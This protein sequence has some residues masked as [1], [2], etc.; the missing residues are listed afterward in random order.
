MPGYDIPYLPFVSLI[1]LLAL[2]AA[3]ESPREAARIGFAAGT[4]ANLLIYYWIAWTVA[5]PGNLGW[6][7]GAAAAL[8]VSAFVAGF[9]SG[10][11]AV[12]NYCLRR[13]GGFALWAFPFFWT[14]FELGRTHLFTGFPWMLLGYSLAGSPL[15]RQA[16]DLAG[17]LG[18][19]FLIAMVNVAAYR[20]ITAI[21]ERNIRA[22]AVSCLVVIGIPVSMVLY[23]NL[24]LQSPKG[25]R[26]LP[27]RIGISQG[28]IDQNRKWDPAN[29]EETISIYRKLTA[30]AVAQGAR[31][32][33][34]P[35][36]AAPFFYG[37]ESALTEL[38]DNVARTNATPIVF[39][40]PW[41]NPEGGGKYFN[42]VFYLNA[43][44]IPVGR[45]DK[46]HLVPFGEYVPLRHLLPFISKLTAGEEDFSCGTGPLLF[47]IDNTS[48]AASICYEAVFPEIIRESVLAG[49]GWLINVTNDAWFGDTVAPYQHL[50]MARMRAVELRRPMV[51]AANSGISAVID[52][53]GEVVR[54]LGLFKKGIVVADITPETGQTAY[55]KTGEL[56]GFSCIII[57]FLTFLFALR[58]PHGNRYPGG[59]NKRP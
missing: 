1:P 39:G 34:W 4:L 41:F 56:F 48:A 47:G 35:E 59:A 44:G 51:R 52:S 57:G 22:I 33:V 29:Q 54:S 15:L 25:G 21:G 38:V 7:L 10:I 58:G 26:A 19:G 18:L 43:R 50:A 32:V 9:I 31:V 23:G 3:A 55:A 30:D 28:G 36:T 5:I 45:Y 2:S 40:A 17:T 8:S 46:R 42:S 14:L 37:W 24:R 16:A 20:T 12:H 13:L 27:L 6:L 11:C 53:S 49:A